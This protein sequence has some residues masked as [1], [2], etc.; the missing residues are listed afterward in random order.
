MTDL[1]KIKKPLGLLKK[2]TQKALMAHD[3]PIE[4]YTDSGWSV[5][6]NPLWTSSYTYR[7]AP[8][9]AT[10]PSVDWS[11]LDK[12]WKFMAMDRK[13]WIYAYSDRPEIDCQEW[14]TPGGDHINISGLLTSYKPGTCDWRDSLIERPE[15][16]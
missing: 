4:M 7:A 3:G 5:V 13:G 16:V 6:N 11:A 10:K 1:T 9:P 15:G 8:L 12:K 2:K 14:A